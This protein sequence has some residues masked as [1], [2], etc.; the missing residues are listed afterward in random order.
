LE[1][2]K[3]EKYLFALDVNSKFEVNPG[4]KDMTQIRSFLDAIKNR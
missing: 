1:F 2:G 4:V 3:T